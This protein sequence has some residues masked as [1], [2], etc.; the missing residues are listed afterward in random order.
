M[1]K[2][3]YFNL[4][5]ELKDLAVK[6]RESKDDHKND[7]RAF[8]QCSKQGTANDYYD[9]VI[10][11]VKW[12]AIRPTYNKLYSKQ[13]KSLQEKYSL[14]REYRHKHIVYCFARGRTMQQIEPKV[15]EGNEPSRHELERLMKIYDVKEL[16]VL[17]ASA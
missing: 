11:S 9:G 5:Q 10:D 3:Q 7:Q 14:R 12:E 17:E 1:T 13:L 8:S 2:E 15:R 6:I 16:L 4:K